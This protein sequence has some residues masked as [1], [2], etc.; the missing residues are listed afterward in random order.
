MGFFPLRQVPGLSWPE[1]PTGE[2]SQLWGL[3]LELERTQWLAPAEIVEGQLAQARA[4]LGHCAAHVPYYRDTL[5]RA[6]LQPGAVRTLDDFRRVPLLSRRTY[7]EQFPSFQATGLPPGMARIGEGKTSGTGG[8]PISV[9]QTNLVALWYF[10]CCLR[11]WHWSG[12]NPRGSLAS[13]RNLGITAADPAQAAEGIVAPCWMGSLA[14]LLQT[15]PSYGL[16]IRQEPRRQLE[17]LFRVRP[18][19]L[20]STT[21]NLVF[22]AGLIRDGGQRLPGLRAIQSIAEALSEEA[23]A[24]VEEAFGVPVKDLYSCTE[25]GYVA[26][27]CPEGHGLHVHAENVLVEVLDEQGRPCE[28]GETGRVVL[29]ALHNYLTPFVRYEVLDRATVGARC[30]CGRGLPLLT[31]VD[32]KMRPML[33]L[34]GGGHKASHQL[35]HEL[36]HLDVYHQHQVVQRAPDHFVVRVVPNRL[37]AADS[38][39]RVVRCVR[40]FLEAPVRVDVE[41]LDRLETTAAGKLRDVVIE[42]DS[43]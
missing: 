24:A 25:A 29:T 42:C 9:W 28:P 35:V 19:Y 4:L 33:R 22:L 38:A 11:D 12:M 21:S 17:W 13:I 41:V 3:Y 40:D 31:R 36:F 30:P 18:D 16:D 1:V 39:D 26:S 10:A 15:G 23:R 7:Q 37:W 27:S 14:P 8:V 6:G 20:L 2:V 5:R 43:E 32:G 34:P